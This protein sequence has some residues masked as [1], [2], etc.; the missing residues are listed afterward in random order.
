MKR[1][2][3][4][5]TFFS[6]IL[7]LSATLFYV[8]GVFAKKMDTTGYENL[9]D[10][11]AKDTKTEAGLICSTAECRELSEKLGLQQALPY[12]EICQ[13]LLKSDLCKKVPKEKLIKCDKKTTA[14][15]STTDSIWGCVK[16]SIGE[17]L[18]A[19]WGI[20]KWAKANVVSSDERAKTKLHAS[21]ALD[22]TKLYLNTEYEKAYDQAK[23]PGRGV[24]ATLA[25]SAVF[26]KLLYDTVAKAISQDIEEWDCLSQE[27]QAGMV[28]NYMIYAV[29]AGYS[30]K[31]IF[32][33]VTLKNFRV[34]S[35]FRKN[36][37]S[38]DKQKL[39]WL[40]GAGATPLGK[41]GKIKVLKELADDPSPVVRAKAA[42]SIIRLLPEN[43]KKALSMLREL[44]GDKDDLVRAGVERT[45][46][47]NKPYFVQNSKL[48]KKRREI[49]E[50]LRN[51]DYSLLRLNIT[52]KMSPDE[53]AD[54]VR[55]VDLNELTPYD[56]EKIFR[57][58]KGINLKVLDS[59]KQ[60]SL[61][62]LVDPKILNADDLGRIVRLL[63]LKKLDPDDLTRIVRGGVDLKKLSSDDLIRIVHRVYPDK[64]SPDDLARIVQ[65]ADLKK[66]HPYALTRIVRGANLENL[67]P[68]DLTRI[69]R[70]VTMKELFPSDL[71]KIFNHV[72]TRIHRRKSSWDV[73]L[74][75]L[76]G[77]VMRKDFL[78]ALSPNDLRRIVRNVKP[79]N[80]TNDHLKNIMSL[81]NESV[82]K[83]LVNSLLDRQP[84]RLGV[85]RNIARDSKTVDHYAQTLIIKRKAGKLSEAQR[86]YH[87][88]N[89]M[90]NSSSP[91]ARK[92]VE[93]E[94]IQMWKN[95][96]YGEQSKKS[97]W[98]YDIVKTHGTAATKKTM[99]VRP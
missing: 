21:K 23:E 37:L 13:S 58:H 69:V 10:D 52:G 31:Q 36:H 59:N 1:L 41:A 50:K 85:Y 66:L 98:L 84:S 32:N 38:S 90:K 95:F 67:N 26:S 17:M 79:D 70:N 27:A 3:I 43:N 82:K 11:L 18:A 54:F 2:K 88:Q 51:V 89:V 7:M 24:K 76:V 14:Y 4:I 62:R 33:M 80:F 83:N 68:Y 16:Y 39:E 45:L 12:R 94:I 22:S 86:K 74:K 44:S 53:L 93:G 73:D 99:K 72:M 6:L 42:D 56:F 47:L 75:K 48:L 63:D 97:Q 5:K 65:N 96:Y 87:Y 9:L 61:F 78:E 35:A 20:M 71:K 8:Q 49:L 60:A 57:P 64:L 28:C 77:Q 40:E 46:M 29:G 91:V 92:S 25:L 30:V 34:M 55:R 15:R 19:M 81:G